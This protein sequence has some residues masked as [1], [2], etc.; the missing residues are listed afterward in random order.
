M[1]Y[2]IWLFLLLLS[3]FS[4]LAFAA[5]KCDEAANGA[6]QNVDQIYL[7]KIDLWIKVSKALKDKGL[8]PRKYP[9]IMPDGSVELLDLVDVV[10]KLIKQRAEAYN[11][12]QTAGDDCNRGIA[13]YQKALDIAVYFATGGLSAILPPTMT[14]ID[15]SQILSGNPLGGPGAL[16]PKLRED[17][18]N[19]LGIHGDVACG[20][21]DPLKF[22]RGGC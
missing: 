3:A 16:I 11:Q 5:D 17:I 7:P 20:I 2:R 9:I 22:I 19:G 13:P 21:R 10:E 1:K 6:K 18:L 14:K 15:A 12:I 4:S 8:D